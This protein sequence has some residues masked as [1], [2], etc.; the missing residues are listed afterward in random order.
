MSVFAYNPEAVKSW[1]NSVLNYLNGGS[2]SISACSKRF[3]E[4]IEKLVQPNVWTGAAAAQNYQNFLETHQALVNFVN[5]FGEAFEQAMNSINQSVANLEIS[6]LGTNTNV[7]SSFGTLSYDQLTALSQE[8]INKDVVRYDYATISSIG[9]ALNSI[10]SN[11]EGINTSLNSKI[12]E[13]NN[14]SA[15]WDG[16]AAESAKESLLNTLKNNMTK[17]MEALNVCIKN[18]AA[19]AEAAQIADTAQ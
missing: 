1:A 2:E 19:A 9:A 4:Q 14:G 12:N 6:N 10:L 16:S 8:N 3:S 5:S 17:V 15:V 13:L 7:S 11:L 18:I